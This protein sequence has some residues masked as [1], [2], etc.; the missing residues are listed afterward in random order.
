[1]GTAV[2]SLSHWHAPLHHG[3]IYHV[4]HSSAP[5]STWLADCRQLSRLYRLFTARGDAT[6]HPTGQQLTSLSLKTAS[7]NAILGGQQQGVSGLSGCCRRVWMLLCPYMVAEAHTAGSSSS[8]AGQAAAAVTAEGSA[9][10]PSLRRQCRELE[11]RA[12]LM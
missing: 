8:T 1:M 7:G 3:S 9:E 10:A 4:F 2:Q 5:C 11:C 6:D 12:Q